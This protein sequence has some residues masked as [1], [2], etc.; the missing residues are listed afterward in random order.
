MKREMFKLLVCVES[1]VEV[2]DSKVR[3]VSICW[4]VDVFLVLFSRL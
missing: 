4:F 2:E 1:L 3:K